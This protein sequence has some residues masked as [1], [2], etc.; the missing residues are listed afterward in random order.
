MNAYTKEKL[1]E[2][3]WQ[4]HLEPVQHHIERIKRELNK[5]AEI[6][7]SAR[8]HLEKAG[9]LFETVGID[10]KHPAT[11]QTTSIGYEFPALTDFEEQLNEIKAKLGPIGPQIHKGSEPS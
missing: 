9:Q 11:I 1:L 8:E 4:E 6:E 7:K 5:I 2:V 3:A 10:P